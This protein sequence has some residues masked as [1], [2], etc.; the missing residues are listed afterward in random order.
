MTLLLVSSLGVESGLMKYLP[1]LRARGE[2]ETAREVV[3]AALAGKL[4]L[5]LA[6]SAGLAVVARFLVGRVFG[7]AQLDALY[8]Y[9]IPGLLVPCGLNATFRSILEAHYRQRVVNLVDVAQ[10]I[11]RLS[12]VAFGLWWQPG[13]LAVLLGNLALEWIVLAIY[14]VAARD[15]VRWPRAGLTPAVRKLATFSATMWVMTLASFLIGKSSDLLLLGAF[16]DTQAV[17]MYNLAYTFASQAFMALT[18]PLGNLALVAA[19]ELY[20]SPEKDSGLVKAA[21]LLLKYHLLFVPPVC[22]GGVL[23]AEPIVRCLYGA[24]YLPAAQLLQLYLVVFAV[25]IQFSGP[26]T[27]LLTSMERHRAVMTSAVCL[28]LFNLAVNCVL[29]PRF[30][31]V[32]ALAGTGL[33]N[34]LSV[35]WLGGLLRREIAWQFPAVF[36]L[37]T[38]LAAATMGGAALWLAPRA[39]G[40]PSLT[41]I[42]AGCALVYGVALKYLRPFSEAD[43]ALLG[44]V[45]LPGGGMLR[46]LLAPA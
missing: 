9:L 11:G 6:V 20:G 40:W 43:L 30:G 12:A 34:V 45:R 1:E 26:F 27:V 8:L 15:A 35:I 17:G 41:L 44:G 32:G 2:P 25:N 16:A 28:G 18:L 14:A 42:V 19:S 33:V 5:L 23:L 38:L 7:G 39:T 13:V 21:D 24:E 31:A 37:K 46:R 22:L 29:I 10:I 3:G 36:G 4:A